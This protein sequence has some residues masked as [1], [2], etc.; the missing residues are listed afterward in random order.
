MTPFWFGL[1]VLGIYALIY[2]FE[3]YVLVPRIIG[4]HLKLHPLVVL[5]GVVAGASI[6]GIIGID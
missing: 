2:Q 4:Y 1:L 5:V 6:A 3:N